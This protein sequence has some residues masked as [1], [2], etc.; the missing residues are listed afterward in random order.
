MLKQAAILEIVKDERVYTFI[1]PQ[2]APIG[3]L[4]DVL[5]QMRAFVIERIQEAAKAEVQK[6]E[7]P[8]KT[9]E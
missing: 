5:F 8:E 1:L 6:V 4:H 2:S 9:G 3:E 7:E